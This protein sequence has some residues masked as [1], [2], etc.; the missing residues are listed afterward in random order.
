MTFPGAE[1]EV[2]PGECSRQL[3]NPDP[4]MLVGLVPVGLIIDVAASWMQAYDS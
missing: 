3:R 2:A 4:A 1:V